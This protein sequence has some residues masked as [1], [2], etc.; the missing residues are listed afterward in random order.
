MRRHKLTPRAVEAVI[1]TLLREAENGPH[2]TV[3]ALA[4]RLQ[5][6]RQTLLVG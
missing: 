6:N 1:D 3:S 2:A 4:R 5:V